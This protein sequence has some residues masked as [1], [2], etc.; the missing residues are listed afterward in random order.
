[1]LKGLLRFFKELENKYAIT[2][3]G[4]FVT[5]AAVGFT[6]YQEFLS[7]KRPAITFEI[8][9][10]TNVLDVKENLTNFK[11]LFDGVDIREKG[12]SLSVINLRVFNPSNLDI[13]QTH[14][15]IGA[16]LGLNI[17]TGSI[18]RAD[19]VDT[20][21]NYLNERFQL[22]PFGEQAI[23]FSDA[24]LESKEWVRIKLLVLHPVTERPT[25]NPVGKV[26][27]VKEISV[28]SNIE[29]ENAPSFL[30]LTFG[31][32]PLIQAV[33]GFSYFF[34]FIFALF[35]FF[36]PI[37]FIA[38]R[39]ERYTRSKAVKEFKGATKLELPERSQE[40]FTAFIKNGDRPIKKLY[41]TVRRRDFI[42]VDYAKYMKERDG[43]EK[44]LLDDDLEKL[45]ETNSEP[46]MAGPFISNIQ[47]SI[48][49]GLVIVEDNT[50]KI[51]EEMSKVVIYFHRYLM[52]RGMLKE[53]NPLHESRRGKARVRS[54]RYD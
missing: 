18:V 27:G 36:T 8:E 54:T 12:L 7:D 2:V 40:V 47:A 1:V 21:S 39:I 37:I 53:T 22:K 10:N 24:I 51:D 41:R 45:A 19:V 31:G 38:T 43:F 44:R 50:P 6:V 46:V 52:N 5:V 49:L 16:P 14:Y 48:D 3:F 30:K 34:G 26:A 20:S 11:L 35:A 25:I 33:R 42:S 28:K 15:D 17:S 23:R 29:D 9:G 13:L 4:A 32:A